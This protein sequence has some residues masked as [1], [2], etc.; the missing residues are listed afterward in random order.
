LLHV[1]GGVKV[2]ST[3]AWSVGNTS[4]AELATYRPSRAQLVIAALA[5]DERR[6][7]MAALSTPGNYR[8]MYS[9]LRDGEPVG[10]LLL[11]GKRTA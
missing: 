11:F 9:P 10:I 5:V 6:S 2:K 7:S 4:T 1:V 8:F 3:E